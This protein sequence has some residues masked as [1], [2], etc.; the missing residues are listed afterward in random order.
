M[1][2]MRPPS[3]LYIGRAL[4][5]LSPALVLSFSNLTEVTSVTTTITMTPVNA[6]I[7]ATNLFW[8][9][10]GKKIGLSSAFLST[11]TYKLQ[12]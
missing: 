6:I 12:G 4:A 10:T 1:K 7:Q 9:L 2:H 3:P 11:S 5:L 8:D